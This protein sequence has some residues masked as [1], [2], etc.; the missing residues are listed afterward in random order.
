[1]GIKTSDLSRRGWGLYNKITGV[2]GHQCD[3]SIPNNGLVAGPHRPE[4]S[5]MK[6]ILSWFLGSKMRFFSIFKKLIHIKWNGQYGASECFRGSKGPIF[7][8]ISYFWSLYFKILIFE[9]S[10]FWTFFCNFSIFVDA[11]CGRNRP[12]MAKYL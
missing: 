11:I 6:K 8:Q 9:K 2:L 12:E 1:M 3:V 10:H 5:A 4:K 7:D